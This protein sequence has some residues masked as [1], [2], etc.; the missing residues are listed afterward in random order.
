MSLSECTLDNTP[1]HGFSGQT[2]QAK[3]VDVYDGDSLTLAMLDPPRLFKCRVSG[4]DTPEMR[5]S[6]SAPHREQHVAA[7]FRARN[8]VA[9]LVTDV[10]T[11]PT[12]R[13]LDLSDNTRLV[14][15]RCGEFDKYGRLLVD[16]ELGDASLSET[17]IREGLAHAYGGGTKPTWEFE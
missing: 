16:I 5:P 12:A 17:L 2:L 10:E 14:S 13:K 7:A 6:R 3:V 8:R 15:V 4:V 1:F 11:D 9:Q